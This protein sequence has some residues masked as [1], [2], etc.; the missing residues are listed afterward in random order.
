MA[1]TSDAVIDHTPDQYGQVHPHET[2]EVIKRKMAMFEKEIKKLKSK[3]DKKSIKEAQE[4]CP[5]MLTH[6]FK[7][8]FLRAEVFNADV[9]EVK[10]CLYRSR[11]HDLDQLPTVG[12][13]LIS[14]FSPILF[15]LPFFL[16]CS[17]IPACCHSLWKV[18]DTAHQGVWTG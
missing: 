2:P 8:M 9:S 11:E 12:S 3:E 6:E 5:G 18:L 4:N 15:L 10:L 7:L 14:V 16:F 1:S 17:P 13:Q